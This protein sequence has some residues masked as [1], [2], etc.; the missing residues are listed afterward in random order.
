VLSVVNPER[1]SDARGKSDGPAKLPNNSAV[2][3]RID[4]MT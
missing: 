4:Q 1:G 2:V 3:G